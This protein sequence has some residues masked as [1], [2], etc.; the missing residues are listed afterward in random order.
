MKKVIFGVL[1]FLL[2]AT[3]CS[4]SVEQTEKDSKIN[5]FEA[6]L[7]ESLTGPSEE[8][9][10]IY[11]QFASEDVDETVEA[12]KKLDSYHKDN[13]GNYFKDEY[14]QEILNKSM[15]FTV[16]QEKAYREGMKI[17]AEDIQVE[18]SETNDTAYDFSVNVHL[19]DSEEVWNVEGRINT[20]ENGKITRIRYTNGMEWLQ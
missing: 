16:F 12:L 5:E 20:D 2:V 3:G 13:Y 7:K 9:T 11:K 18:R 10:A 4:E 8:L 15:Y 14:F 17:K 6:M 1:I 19:S